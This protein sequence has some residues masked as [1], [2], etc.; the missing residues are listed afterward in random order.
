MTATRIS[1]TVEASKSKL[2]VFK[3]FKSNVS[4]LLQFSDWI[5]VLA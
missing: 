5:N 4:P 1:A 3:D 2:N